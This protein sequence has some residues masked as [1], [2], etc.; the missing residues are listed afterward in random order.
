MIEFNKNLKEIDSAGIEDINGG[1]KEWQLIG[2][3][4]FPLI[5]LGSL[6]CLGIY[7]GYN[8]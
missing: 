4:A 7:N 5:G 3:C 6:V 8:N 1:S 2:V